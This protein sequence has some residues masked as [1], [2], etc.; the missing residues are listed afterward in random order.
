MPAWASPAG[1]QRWGDPLRSSATGYLHHAGGLSLGPAH[2]VVAGG[3]GVVV[4]VVVVVVA[5]GGG[6]VVDD[7][8]GDERPLWLQTLG[9]RIHGA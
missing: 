2:E 8:A 1:P 4:V 3:D 9:D 7:D 5:A 6:A